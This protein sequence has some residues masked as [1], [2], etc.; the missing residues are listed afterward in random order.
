MLIPIPRCWWWSGW[1]SKA[2]SFIAQVRSLTGLNAC[3][4]MSPPSPPRQVQGAQRSPNPQ[5]A[6]YL[7]PVHATPS[8]VLPSNRAF[9]GQ[10]PV[11]PS[12]TSAFFCFVLFCFLKKSL[13]PGGLSEV[14]LSFVLLKLLVRGERK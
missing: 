7:L 4:F 5:V 14:C 6:V 2:V 3:S 11:S 13:W 9:P 10:V 12:G 8:L 1:G